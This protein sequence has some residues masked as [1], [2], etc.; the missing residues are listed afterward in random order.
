MDFDV[1]VQLQL[2]AAAPGVRGGHRACEC[3]TAAEYMQL[4][5]MAKLSPRTMELQVR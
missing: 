5:A 4:D 3:L 1:V 2:I